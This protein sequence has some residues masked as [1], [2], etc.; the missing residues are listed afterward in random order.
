MPA[1]TPEDAEPDGEQLQA[2]AQEEATADAD[3]IADLESALG[4]VEADAASFVELEA[5]LTDDGEAPSAA[6]VVGARTVPAT[7]VPADYPRQIVGEEALVLDLAVGAD[8]RVQTYFSW[9][10]IDGD[11]LDRLLAALDIS[12]ESFANLNGRRLLVTVE[13][14]Y[15]VPLVP[16]IPPS[17]SEKGLYGI[18]AGHVANL[19]LLLAA[20]ASLISP[21]ALFVGLLL[22]NLVGIPVSTYLDAAHLRSTTDWDQGPEFW[23]TLQALPGLNL[24]ATLAYLRSRRDARSLD[25]S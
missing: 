21:F 1:D 20:A 10:P 5:E 19:G 6:R 24:L 3:A 4:S 22:V 23:A 15:V 7:E 8:R 17:G 14:G 12:R 13:D 11:P 18:L 2:T 16:P 25:R 9:P